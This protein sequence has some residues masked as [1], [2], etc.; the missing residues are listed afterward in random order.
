MTHLVENTEEL[1]RFATARAPGAVPLPDGL[2]ELDDDAEVPLWLASASDFAGAGELAT[3]EAS[4][5]ELDDTTAVD[6]LLASLWKFYLQGIASGRADGALLQ[7]AQRLMGRATQLRSGADSEQVQTAPP[8]NPTVR[9]PAAFEA[10]LR[11]RRLENLSTLADE[12][13]AARAQLQDRLTQLSAFEQELLA[14]IERVT[15]TAAPLPYSIKVTTPVPADSRDSTYHFHPAA[16]PSQRFREANDALERCTMQGSRP[17]A[18]A[19][20]RHAT[21]AFAIYKLVLRPRAGLSPS[22]TNSAGRLSA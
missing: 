4:F 18:A 2:I 21:N 20:A 12:G 19:H 1:F 3:L 8:F 10:F 16:D 11:Q 7:R 13:G 15:P 5:D 22:C 6:G 9:L 17:P 14:V